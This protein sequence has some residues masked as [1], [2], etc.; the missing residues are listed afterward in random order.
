MHTK[1]NT[2]QNDPNFL[3]HDTW[4]KT[5]LGMQ[6][7]HLELIGIL[8]YVFSNKIKYISRINI[9]DNHKIVIKSPEVYFGM[10]R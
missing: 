9:S 2:Q 3:T 1:I 6:H 10:K 4:P 8:I 5:S 7:T